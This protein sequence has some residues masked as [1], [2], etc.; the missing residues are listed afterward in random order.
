VAGG[1][2]HGQPTET[3]KCMEVKEHN[4]VENYR[5]SAITSEISEIDGSGFWR[6]TAAI[7]TTPTAFA[8]PAVKSIPVIPDRFNSEQ[9]ALETILRLTR[10]VVDS[11]MKVQQAKYTAQRMPG[12]A[13]PAL[14]GLYGSLCATF[15]AG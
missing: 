14:H 7:V 8:P 4:G 11:V 9:Q 5:R 10:G 1:K 15:P 12:A 2:V 13:R 6:G 3:S